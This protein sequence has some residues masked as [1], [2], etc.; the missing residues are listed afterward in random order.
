MKML[1]YQTV[2]TRYRIYL[3]FSQKTMIALI[4][5]LRK[6]NLT[7]IRTVLNHHLLPFLD[8]KPRRLLL[9][10]RIKRNR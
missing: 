1:V 7:T 4:M 5:A 9:S 10:Q 2:K 3:T 6:V 8:H